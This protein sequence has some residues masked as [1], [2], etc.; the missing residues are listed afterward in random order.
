MRLAWH[1]YEAEEMSHGH[2]DEE[3]AAMDEGESRQPA[4]S[5]RLGSVPATKPDGWF[6]WQCS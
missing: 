1:L 4:T 2:S 3:L 6:F 5:T